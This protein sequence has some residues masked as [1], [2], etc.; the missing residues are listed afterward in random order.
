MPRNKLMQKKIKSIKPRQTKLRKL[1][2]QKPSQKKLRIWKSSKMFK[3]K[4]SLMN[5]MF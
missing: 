1:R 5:A 2:K 3:I 4:A